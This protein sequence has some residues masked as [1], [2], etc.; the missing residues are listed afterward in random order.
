MRRRRSKAWQTLF[1]S[2]G[3]QEELSPQCHQA[4][5]AAAEIAASAEKGPDDEDLSGI[6]IG[7]KRA[8]I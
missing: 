1:M 3:L 6:S 4:A 8:A 7:I 5:V 2:M